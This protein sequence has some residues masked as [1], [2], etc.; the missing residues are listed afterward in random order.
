MAKFDASQSHEK[1]KRAYKHIFDLQI[2]TTEFAKSGFHSV[3]VE[4]CTWTHGWL[5]NE[6]AITINPTGAF[7]VQVALITG[8]ALHNLR[9][10]LDLT[11]YQSV[12]ACEGEP[13]NWTR[14]PV[15]DTREKLI[16][17]TDQAVKDERITE[18]VR[19]FLVD[20]IKPYEAGNYT[21]WALHRLN[22]RDKHELLIPTFE[23]MG[24]RGIRLRNHEDILLDYPAVLT[25]GSCRQRLDETYYGRNPVVESQ[26][27]A[28]TGIGF[29]YGIP[30][31]GENV[32]RTLDGIAKEVTR[33]IEA[34]E[35]L[36]GENKP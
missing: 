26:G 28:A 4:E 21:I 32:I 22:M 36:L 34:F 12:L 33:T 9:S 23:M 15:F 14:F 30:F 27:E 1:V 25:S 19:K 13:T 10:A 11:Y 31:E 16:Q 18:V 5:R 29:N 17:A 8:D 3:T 35:L 2:L 7:R 20:V 6:L 24:I